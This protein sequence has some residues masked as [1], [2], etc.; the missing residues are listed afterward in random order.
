MQLLGGV[1]LGGHLGELVVELG[2]LL[3]LDAGDLDRDLDV[4]ADQVAAHELGG[5]G[6]LVAGGHADQGL[7]EA[8]EH[9]AATDLVGHAGDLA[10]LDGLAVLGGG[11]VDGHEVAVGGRALDVGEGAEALTQRLDLLLDVGVADL[12]VLDLGLEAVV[13]GQLELGLDVDLGGEL[14]GL[15]V[16]ELGD[17]DLGLRQR[18]ERVLLQR[19]DVLLRGRPR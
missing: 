16:L 1:E 13:G 17:L 7:V 2:Q 18:L 11:Q 15:V 19:L 10:A 4:L 12:D 14:E 9:A 8:V 3:L 5:E 6:L